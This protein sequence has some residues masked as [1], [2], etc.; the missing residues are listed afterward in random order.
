MEADISLQSSSSA[1]AAALSKSSFK[2]RV[3]E[4]EA[5]KAFVS[6]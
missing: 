5:S 6:P 3:E 2:R 4:V 1:L